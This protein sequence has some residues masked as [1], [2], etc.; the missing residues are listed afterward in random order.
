[1]PAPPPGSPPPDPPPLVAGHLA[2]GRR[3][4]PDLP[5]T[6]QD[7]RRAMFYGDLIRGRTVLVHFMSVAADR[8]YPATRYLTPLAR[9]LGRRLGREVA[10][11]SVTTE[12]EADS[13]EA[14]RRFAAD[15]DLPAGWQFLTGE[16]AALRAIHAA[17]FVHGPAPTADGVPRE[18]KLR[19]PEPL[20]PDP[21]DRARFP[22]HPVHP[23][24]PHDCS[25]G[26]VR[27]GNDVSGLWGSA[28]VKTDPDLM[29]QRLDWIAPRAR[30]AVAAAPRRGGPAPLV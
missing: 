19:E 9:R 10:L 4:L 5:V 16:P 6:R 30:S 29:L 23:G 13:P 12:P 8:L 14:L 11:L 7:G 25:L 27:Y 22:S 15:R 24:R 21:F 28:P 1:M 2:T 3:P 26:L 20:E 18:P 17:F